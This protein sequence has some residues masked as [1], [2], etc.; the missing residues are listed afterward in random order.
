MVWN[1]FKKGDAAETAQDAVTEQPASQSKGRPTPKRKDAQKQNLRPLVPTDRKASAKAARERV[2]KREDAEYEAMRT[3][4]TAH[5]PRAERL[6]WRI[7]IRD[8]VDA[9]FNL[10]EFFIPVAGVVLIC[11]LFFGSMPVVLLGSTIALYGYLFAAI[12]DVVFMWRKLKRKLI[13]KYGEQ[14]VARGSR[15]A[16]YAWSRAIQIRRFRLPKPR[17]AKRGH[18][19]E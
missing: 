3:G 12:I 15:S 16:T 8:Y 14:S 17:H 10:G 6:P 13:D 18:W 2:R 19:P 5:M 7:Y 4:D 9:R 1:P 11:M